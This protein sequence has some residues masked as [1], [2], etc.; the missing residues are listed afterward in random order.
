MDIDMIHRHKSFE[1]TQVTLDDH[2]S[3]IMFN[4]CIKL[5]ALQRLIF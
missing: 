5:I 4:L 1:C 3:S 2:K